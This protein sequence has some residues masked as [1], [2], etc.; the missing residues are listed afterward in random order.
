[1]SRHLV[2]RTTG[3]AGAGSIACAPERGQCQ[4]DKRHDQNAAALAAL[5]LDQRGRCAFM[6]WLLLATGP[7]I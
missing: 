6:V 4:A 3:A 7:Q 2:S 1:M 5:L